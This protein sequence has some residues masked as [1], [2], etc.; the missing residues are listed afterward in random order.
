[1]G[2]K[3]IASFFGGKPAAKALAAAPPSAGKSTKSKKAS[4]QVLKETSNAAGKKRA[5]EVCRAHW[6]R[7]SHELMVCWVMRFPDIGRILAS[8]TAQHAGS[9]AA[10]NHVAISS[11]HDALHRVPTMQ[12]APV[13]PAQPAEVPAMEPASTAASKAGR[14]KPGLKRLRKG[15]AGTVASSA[16]EVRCVEGCLL[17]ARVLHQVDVQQ[18]R[19]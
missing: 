7:V 17:F 13:E 6:Q 3:D 2:Q 12:E 8:G 16:M 15:P 11:A 10:S 14:G 4:P 9:P 19:A 1:M 5:R 18:S